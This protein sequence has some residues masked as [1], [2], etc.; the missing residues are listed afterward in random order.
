MQWWKRREQYLR[1]RMSGGVGGETGLVFVFL[2][3]F[4]L[5]S[6]YILIL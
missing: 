3:R 5:R 2:M 4:G 6:Q 1:I